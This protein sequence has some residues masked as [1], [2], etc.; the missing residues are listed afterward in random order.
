MRT[1]VAR[2]QVSRKRETERAAASRPPEP[3]DIVSGAGQPLDVGLR[4]ELEARL[5]HDFSRVRIHTDP[6][7]AALAELLGADAVAVGQDVFFAEGRFHPETSAGR[8]LLAHELLHTV[9]VPHAP[10][11]LR[12]G[13]EPGSL[14]TPR[15]AVELEAEEGVRER[16]PELRERGSQV[17]SWLRYTRG[18]AEQHRA[19]QLDPAAVV[20][21]LVAGLLRSLRGDATDASGRVRL[22]L[23]RLAPVLRDLV[24][25]RL[26]S[27]LPSA[28]YRRVL[29]LVEEADAAAAGGPVDSAGTPEPVT[30][31]AERRDIERHDTAEA[32]QSEAEQDEQRDAD[33]K[34]EPDEEPVEPAP[35]TEDGKGEEPEQDEEEEQEKDEKEQDKEKKEEDEKKEDEEKEDEEKGEKGKQKEKEE[36]EKT[37]EAPKDAEAAAAAQP[38]AQAPGAP[39]AAPPPGQGPAAGAA[40]AAET[41]IAD[42]QP[43]PARPERVEQAAAQPDS[44]LVRHGLADRREDEERLEEQEKPLGLEPAAETEVDAPEPA[45]EAPEAARPER[46]ELKPEDYLPAADLDLSHVPTAERTNAREGGP[47]PR[48]PEP[49]SFPAPPPTKAEQQEEDEE[50]TP[51][52]EAAEAGP[53]PAP[54][55]P[56]E[57]P[58]AAEEPPAPQPL[59]AEVG[60]EPRAETA[61]RTPI[62]PAEPAEPEAPSAGSRMPGAPEQEPEPAAPEL[63]APGPAGPEPAAPEPARPGPVAGPAPVGGGG[64]PIG[65][66]A[67]RPELAQQ[68]E[69]PGVAEPG[70]E[71]GAPPIAPE[72]S[73][74]PGGGACAGA[75]EPTT[76]GA[77]PEGGEGGCA[78]GGGGAAGAAPPPAEQQPAPSD[79]SGQPPEAALATVGTLPPD[80]MR[81][82]L[83]GV[84]SAVSRDVGEQQNALA[85]APPTMQRPS[86]APRTMSGPPEA[87]PPGDAER[88]RLE[89]AEAERAEQQKKQQAKEVQGTDPAAQ[90]QRPQVAGGTDGKLSEREVRNV[91]QA[92]DNVPTTDP[93]LHTT[94][95]PVQKVELKGE[96]DPVRT[97]Q[98]AA[99]LTKSSQEIH[100][101]GR[102]EA[103]KPLGEDQIFPNA[104]AETLTAQVPSGGGPAGPAGP[105]GPGAEEPGVA[106]VA[107]QERGPQ[108]QAGVAQGQAQMGA[109][110]QNQQQAQAQANAQHQAEV[111]QAV[112]ENAQAQA[113]ERGKVAEDAAAKRE[114]WRGEQDKKIE[115]TGAEAGKEHE[116][117]RAGIVQEK[118]ET[119][120]KNEAKQKEDNDRIARE[121]EQAEEKARKEKERKKE[122]SEGGIFGWIAS[123]VKSFFEGLLNAITAIFDAA[124]KLVNTIVKEFTKIVTGL[125]DLARNAIIGL[126]NTLANILIKLCDVLAVFFPELAARIRKAIETLRDAAIAV[127]N[128]L[129]DALKAGVEFLLN[130]LAQ[131]LTGLLRLLEAGLKAAV[132]IVEG[133]VN[134]AIEFAKAAIQLL[135]KFAAIIAD[136]A[137]MGVGP[138]L[139]KLGSSAKEGIQNHLWGAIKSAVKRWFN[140]KVESILGLGKAVINVLIKG[141]VSMAQI[142]KMAWDALIA[143]LP[144]I[145][146]MVIIERLV[147]L[148][149]P[150]AGAVLAVVQGLMAAWGTISK[151]LA[152][153]GAFIAFLM[154]VK[155]G[156]AACLFAAAVAAGVVALLE[157]I[158]NF[159]MAKLA[160]AAKGVGRTLQGMAKK[161]TAGLGRA[162][163]GARK[164]AGTAVNSARRGLKSAS[165]ALRPPRRPARPAGPGAARRPGAPP[166]TRRPGRPGTGPGRRVPERRP[167]ARRPSRRRDRRREDERETPPRRVSPARA[168]LNRVKH[169]VRNGLRKVGQALRKVGRKVANSKLG[170][171]LKNGAKKLRDKFQR[172]RDRLKDRQKQ[173][174]EDRRRHEDQRRKN[175][176]QTKDQRLALIVARIRPKLV[177]LLRRGVYER[178]LNGVLAGMRIWY[179]LTGLTTVGRPNFRVVATLNPSASPT[180]GIWR[181]LND[182]EG[183]KFGEK[184]LRGDF[185]NMPSE[186]M[187][188][189]LRYTKFGIP[190]NQMLRLVARGA[191]PS[192]VL[193]RWKGQ[194]GKGTKIRNVFGGATPTPEQVQNVARNPVRSRKQLRLL[195]DIATAGNREEVLRDILRSGKKG[196]R[197]RAVFGGAEPTVAQV[198]AVSRSSRLSREQLALLGEVTAAGGSGKN[199]DLMGKKLNELLAKKSFYDRVVELF[200]GHFPTEAE[201]QSDLD[202]VRR[203]VNQPVGEDVVVHRGLTGVRF[204]GGDP[205]KPKLG[206]DPP[207]ERTEPGLMS[208]SVGASAAFGMFKYQLHLRVPKGARG[209]WVGVTSIYPRQRELILAPGTRY[210]ITH[211]VDPSRSNRRDPTWHIYAEV[212]LPTP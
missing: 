204:L 192:E 48:P 163:K 109:E 184:H 152:A 63:A 31:A 79:V 45:P 32:G 112:Q 74:E 94:V 123:K 179:R 22:Q 24:L 111:T 169:T 160:M 38:I 65:A 200:D 97:D 158:T 40:P 121:R 59:D 124:V 187:H 196:E 101:G 180:D 194:T 164:A 69:A 120:Q 73:L 11:P 23:G 96:T 77:K 58:E 161:I 189:L 149:V 197:L 26:E 138:W 33:E 16:S 186:L 20:D 105:G 100:A 89:K 28:E 51:E 80:K 52:P 104:P 41:G 81:S 88:V 211:V 82:S 166:R 174:Q 13:R 175:E 167:E 87:A 2:Q 116:K 212:H 209:L 43:G 44:P 17:A 131:A 139:G 49:P 66:D 60:P 21:R 162:G 71:A 171:A 72:A 18:T 145:I 29:E 190:Y 84:D 127:V 99:E 172:T 150:A 142:G 36:G 168:A 119:D 125:I 19:E 110:R 153:I 9:Q 173:R 76:E 210:T 207:E 98:Q 12:L 132:K 14:S 199:T 5:G 208:T 165:Q 61:D 46:P 57:P 129:A 195:S 78:G 3:K 70:A 191:T 140:E 6:D 206:L 141:C 159:L 193:E 106:V 155:S 181:E 15:D 95:G 177:S 56:P 137:S 90:A 154:A 185:E 122:E 37:E 68:P 47:A 183:E 114:E 157:F 93:A 55:P 10:G 107:Q 126:I 91:E 135:G 182:V 54:Q 42:A 134:A 148:I 35:E 8:R 102:E 176:E 156:P 202:N 113:A 103:A 75:P 53:A 1:A 201:I 30:D 143:S 130:K 67:G 85:A 34:S 188:A 83:S 136:I 7:A 178:V 170:R 50:P 4:R 146:I 151:I 198:L 86:G 128:K 27:R 39:G 115:E 133:V 108:I 203:A 92:V 62:T 118:T 25:T 117:S 64:P 147:S 205:A 144:M